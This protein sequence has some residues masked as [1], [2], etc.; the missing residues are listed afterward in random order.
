[1]TMKINFEN[2]TIQSQSPDFTPGRVRIKVESCRDHRSFLCWLDQRDNSLSSNFNF[3][4]QTEL[5]DIWTKLTKTFLEFKIGDYKY[6]T[7]GDEVEYS[8]QPSKSI[9]VQ[10]FLRY[11]QSKNREKI[12][13]ILTT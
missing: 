7:M 4:E 3:S 5:L 2:F 1:M 8:Y 13:Q 11:L 12:I 9:D 10:E 6:G